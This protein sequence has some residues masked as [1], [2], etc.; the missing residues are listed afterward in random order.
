MRSATEHEQS[1][2]CINH[3]KQQKVHHPKPSQLS[4]AVVERDEWRRKSGGDKMSS[5]QRRTQTNR[6]HQV[7]DQTLKTNP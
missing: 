6:L 1:R 2:V 5:L 7:R 4:E 3:I